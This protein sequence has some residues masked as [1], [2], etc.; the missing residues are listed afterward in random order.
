M[1]REDESP[2]DLSVEERLERFIYT[3]DD[4]D[5]KERYVGGKLIPRPFQK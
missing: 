4:R 1:I 2:L 5:I 3:G